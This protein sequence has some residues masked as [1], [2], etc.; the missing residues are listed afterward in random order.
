MVETLDPEEIIRRLEA[1]L[2]KRQEKQNGN[3]LKDSRSTEN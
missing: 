2:A 1:I 3:E